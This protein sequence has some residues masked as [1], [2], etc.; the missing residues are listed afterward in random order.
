MSNDNL[1]RTLLIDEYKYDMHIVRNGID[2]PDALVRA[3]EEGRVVFFC[4]AGISYES[5]LPDFEKLTRSV[6]SKVG[7]ELNVAEKEAAKL[8]RWDAVLGSLE[9]RIADRPQVRRKLKEVLTPDP[10]KNNSVATHAAILELATTK[11]VNPRLQLVTTNFDRLFEPL[12]NTKCSW[13]KR[14][15]APLLPT[16]R[17]GL[18]NGIVYLHGLL[19]EDD[20]ELDLS[21]LVVSSGDFGRAYLAEAWAARFVAELLRNY[22]VCFIGYSLGDQTVRYLMDAVDVYNRIGDKTEPVYMFTDAAKPDVLDQ[23]ESI[24]RIPYDRDANGGN[25]AMLHQTIQAWAR[26]YKAGLDGKYELIRDL[27]K[28]NPVEIPD[29]GYIDQM[30]W[31]L[32]DSEKDKNRTVRYFSTLED[33]PNFGWL[34][35]F[36]KKGFLEGSIFSPSR[37]FD[38]KSVWLGN[39]ILRRMHSR[40]VVLWVVKNQ[41]KIWPQFFRNAEYGCN[42]AEQSSDSANLK[43]DDFARRLWRLIAI[44]RINYE[45]DDVSQ[46]HHD[47]VHWITRGEMDVLKFNRLRE[48]LKPTI[49]IRPLYDRV[50]KGP[51]GLFSGALRKGVYFRIGYIGTNATG[52]LFNQICEKLKGRLYEI[53][54]AA[55]DSLEQTLNEY[56]YLMGGDSEELEISIDVPSVEEHWQNKRSIGGLPNIVAVIR[57]GWLELLERDRKRAREVALKWLRSKHFLFKRIGLFAAKMSDVI[58]EEEWLSVLTEWHGY[59]LWSSTARREASRLIIAKASRLSDKQLQSLTDALVKG[60]PACKML[61]LAFRTSRAVELAD[62]AKFIWLSKLQLAIG[63]LPVNGQEELAR[64]HTKYPDW[65]YVEDESNEFVGWGT[66]SG[67]PTEKKLQHDVSVPRYLP[68]LI[69]WLKRDYTRDDFDRRYELD[70]FDRLCTDDQLIVIKAFEALADSGVWNIARIFMALKHWKS[71]KSTPH[72]IKYLTSA[73]PRMPKDTFELIA[74]QSASWCEDVVKLNAISD[75]DLLAIGRILLDANYEFDRVGKRFGSDGDRISDAINHPVGRIVTALIDKSFPER[76]NKGIG[77]AEPYKS[78]FEIVSRS[79]KKSSIHGRLILASRAIAFY[80]A[81]EEWTRHYILPN[82]SWE[83]EDEAIS[84]WQGFLWQRSLHLPLLKEIKE[85]F[86]ATMSHCVLLSDSAHSY[87]SLFV[88][89]AM[90]RLDEFPDSE[91]K[92]VFRSMNVMQLEDAAKVVENRMHNADE[93]NEDVDRIWKEN[94]WP[95]IQGLWPRDRD[96]LTSNICLHL[97][98]ALLYTNSI[99][100]EGIKDFWFLGNCADY[101]WL[102]NRCSKSKSIRRWPREV[103]E[104]LYRSIGKAPEFYEGLDECLKLLVNADKTIV[105][106]SRY[107]HLSRMVDDEKNW[108]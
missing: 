16:P 18:W 37:K 74:N 78:L 8:Q 66:W 34:D 13:A 41:Q 19:P 63:K 1:W 31:A 32:S 94:C 56:A 104:I 53:A 90:L 15:A 88:S 102:L 108:M 99:L 11:D 22:V 83:N 25:H 98:V 73:F 4:G 96:L 89:L 39:W 93:T 45:G 24:I 49:I 81:D 65:L 79:S 77:I 9:N 103:L 92:G 82:S 87:I 51:D 30:M 46:M 54:F 44:K 61:L 69:E 7:E 40:E 14:Y 71:A 12:I 3:H 52:Y 23:N 91:I 59:V 86:L 76:V 27:A 68:K 2:V 55:A 105:A 84:F 6:F 36:E 17:K 10:A 100:A 60:F 72:A 62:H 47:V 38:R 21:N 57:D 28:V 43:L 29:D 67:D 48:I 95:V 70:D 5:N 33:C 35:V 101:Y 64:I 85:S 107:K 50:E 58:P 26:R 75:E 42:N 20:D 97:T 106:D 80:Y